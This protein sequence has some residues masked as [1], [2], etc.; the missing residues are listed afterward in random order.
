MEF[1]AVAVSLDVTQDDAYEVLAKRLAERGLYVD[2]LI[3]N[4][5]AGLGGE[6]ADHSPAEVERLI[7][8]NVSALT[9]LMQGA[10]ADMR[11][12]G[13]GHIINMSSLGGY[14]P[15]PQ[16]AAYYASKAYVLSLSEAVACELSGSGI[17]VSVVAPGPV[18][19]GFHATMGAQDAYYRRLLPPLSPDGVAASVYRG[20]R[21]GL[22]V[23]IPGVFN[24][25]MFVALRLMPHPITVPLTGWLLRPRGRRGA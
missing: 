3:N 11:G 14:V 21:L 18:D 6:F 2:V 22:R 16:Q 5:G 25:I 7:A 15:G 13:G 4:A 17:R 12:R 23:I 20:Y 8:L 1:A 24:R 9:R 19:T 10:I